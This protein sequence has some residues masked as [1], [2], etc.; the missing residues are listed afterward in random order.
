MRLSF[1]SLFFAISATAVVSACSSRVPSSESTSLE[2]GPAAA[3]VEWVLGAYLPEAP[4]EKVYLR[5][6]G[7]EIVSIDRSKPPVQAAMPILDTES[8]VFPGLMDLH[9]HIKY[10]VLPLWGAAKGQFLNRYEWRGWGVYKDTVSPAMKPITGH[11][12]CAAVRWAELKALAGGATA[13]EG[14]GNDE[15]CAKDFGTRTVDAKD[16]FE[17]GRKIR[18]MTDVVVPGYVGSVYEKYKIGAKVRAGKSYEQAF[19]EFLRDENFGG[20]L[21]VRQWFEAAKAPN[22]DLATGLT[23][24]VGDGLGVAPGDKN[25]ASFERVIPQLNE[26]LAAKYG[27]KEA[28]KQ[29]D[30]I[31][32]MKIFLFG[33]ATEKGFVQTTG[34]FDDKKAADYLKMGGV[35]TIPSPVRRYIGM[36]EYPTR[37]SLLEFFKDKASKP[38][39]LMHLGEGMQ[40]DGY[41][42]SE[43][44]YLKEFGLALPGVTAIHAVGMNA[45]DLA[46]AA[47]MGIAIVWSPFSNLLLYGETLRVDAALKAGVTVALGSDWSPTGSKNI[48]DEARLAREYIKQNRL[49][50]TD[51]Q[52][53]DMM[54]LNAAKLMRVDQRFGKVA[55]G[56][57]ADLTLVS[58]VQGKDP[59]AT[60]LETTQEDVNLVVV[61]GQPLYGDTQLIDTASRAFN[62]PAEPNDAPTAPTCSFRQTKAFRFPFLSNYDK[63]PGLVPLRSLPQIES[64]L[65]TSLSGFKAKLPSAKEQAKIL[66]LDPI[67]TCEDESYSK[68]Y[69]AFVSQELDNNRSNRSGRRTQD[70]LKTDFTPLKLEDAVE[71]SESM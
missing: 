24:L 15:Q 58:K 31:A 63:K 52:I 7:E 54:T 45:Q 28:K 69:D 13:I 59:Y 21:T 50:V 12:V 34:A 39:V 23:L 17:P 41:N 18:N 43:W 26:L 66:P 56:F 14:I 46:D 38:V 22:R 4:N 60:L 9:G 19:E 29:A 2:R 3:V 53:V 30:Q 65:K 42:R 70:K 61:R 6:R 27:L 48:L 47:R 11:A 10:N 36:W 40:N 37:R 35:L 55:R 51:R 8:L 49:S 71:D 57:A 33:K 16:D 1:R 5:I 62:D 20:K 25:P 64:F 67:F 32:A 44:T 68:R